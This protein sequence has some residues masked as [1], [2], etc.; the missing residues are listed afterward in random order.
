MQ[1]LSPQAL[2]FA[3]RLLGETPKRD[4]FVAALEAGA[5]GERAVLWLSQPP[6]ER[7]WHTEDPF[8][9]QPSFVDRI[10]SMERPGAH[11]LHE[12]GAYY[13]LDLSSV[14]AASV[15]NSE[16][17]NRFEFAPTILDVCAAPGGKSIFAWRCLKPNLLLSNEVIGKRTAALISNM[18][19][20]K[21]AG[22]RVIREDPSRLAERLP[23]F[24]DVVL[25]DAPCSGQS[26]IAKGEDSP[27]CFHPS[28]INTNSNRQR[29]ILANS[30][31]T[32]AAGGRLIY[33]TCTYAREENEG[34][35]EWFLKKFPHFTSIKIPELSNF[36]SELSSAYSYRLWPDLGM[37]AG[38]FVAVFECRDDRPEFD[39]DLNRLRF[40]GHLDQFDN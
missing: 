27:G 35:V 10:H 5:A 2:K 28:V 15:M 25:V 33:M 24:A 13:C 26:L 37:G 20:C 9:W 8:P 34:V 11:E 19:R 6:P 21:I 39:G 7:P 17:F 29:R 3:A 38:A 22:S 4:S 12:A 14:F 31:A 1:R 30:S 23:A 36:Q 18:K 32:V 16:A 40:F